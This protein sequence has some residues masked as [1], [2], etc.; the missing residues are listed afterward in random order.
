MILGNVAKSQED[1]I[2]KAFTASYT[3]EGNG[4]Y[5]N[6]INQM[7]SVYDDKS[8]EINLRLGWLYYSAGMHQEAMN[9]YQKAIN[10]LPYSVEAKLGYVL[11]ASTLGNWDKVIEQYQS[12]LKIDAQNST[13]NYRMGYIYYNR[14]DYANA[15][16]YFEKV[17]NLYPFSID[18]VLMLGWT[19]LQQGNYKNAKI[20]LNR[21]LLINPGNTSAL[22]GL[23]TIK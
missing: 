22:D 2:Q 19:Y 3:E 21:A 17:V 16:K 12:V 7:K 15:Q 13:V 23:K 14:K 11:P 1:K 10:I 18:G 4:S 9:A 5:T 20:M 8:Y 6:A